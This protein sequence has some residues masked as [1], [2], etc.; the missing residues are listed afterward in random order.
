MSVVIDASA[1]LAILFDEPGAEVAIAASRGAYLTT[2][3]LIEVREKFAR[4]TGS[5]EPVPSLLRALE[6]T[7]APFLEHHAVIASDLKGRVGKKDS[8]ADRVCLALAIDK[9][10]PVVT[11]DRKW[12]ELDLGLDVRLIR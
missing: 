8:L 10:L 11:G 1:V 5:A 7:V 6:I 2:V 4:K 12:A 9:G 3:N